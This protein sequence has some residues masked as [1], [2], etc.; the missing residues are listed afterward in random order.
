[1]WPSVAL[2]VLITSGVLKAQSQVYIDILGGHKG[3]TSEFFFLEPIDKS[4]KWTVISR[5]E[6]HLP[7]Y[8]TQHP[9]FVNYNIF[10]YNFKNH[11]GVT[12]GTYA[13]SHYPFSARLGLQYLRE[14]EE[15]LIFANLSSAVTK[16]PDAQM[17]VV[18]GFLP[19]IAEKWR[20]VTRLEART[21]L[22]YAHGHAFSTQQ[23][24]LGAQYN[25]KI[26][27]GIGAEI[28]EHGAGE[29]LEREFNIGPFIRV[30]F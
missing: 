2:L 10:A 29:H 25:E 28:E 6:M 16:D 3:L 1:M 23:I 22:N 12:A 11:F 4:E 14:N 13:S 8:E 19:Q 18:L 20:L 17:L 15:W 26:G 30:N 24:K 21:A 5:S 7:E 27:F 9:A